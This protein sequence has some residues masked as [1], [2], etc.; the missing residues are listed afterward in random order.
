MMGK[1][2]AEEDMNW[3]EFTEGLSYMIT[4]MTS[5]LY[6]KD[7]LRRWYSD[8]GEKGTQLWELVIQYVILYTLFF[9]RIMRKL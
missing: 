2:K 9:H 1:N 6:T 3:K 4:C 5:A 8:D 7:T